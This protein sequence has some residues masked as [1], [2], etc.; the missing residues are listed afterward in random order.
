MQVVEWMLSGSV[1][2]IYANLSQDDIDV[3]EHSS[4]NHSYSS[5]TVPLLVSSQCVQCCL[6][7]GRQENGKN[8]PLLNIYI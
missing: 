4:A 6:K 1:V 2:R 7:N 3:S 8:N 5:N